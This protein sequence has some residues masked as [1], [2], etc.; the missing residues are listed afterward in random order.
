MTTLTIKDLTVSKELDSKAMAAVAGGHSE[1][2]ALL[3]GY[4]E[5]STQFPVFNAAENF[6]Y[7]DSQVGAFN[8]GNVAQTNSSQQHVDQAGNGLGAI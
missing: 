5:I 8:F 4:T 3:L 2:A 6:S 7:Q 1:L